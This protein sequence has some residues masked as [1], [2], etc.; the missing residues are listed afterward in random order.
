MNAL[1]LDEPTSDYWFA[2]G[3]LAEQYGEL[4]VARSDYLRLDR[5][6]FEL[7]IPVSSYYLAQARLAVLSKTTGGSKTARN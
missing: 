5:P 3:R 6:K 7:N 1:N 4:D 2:F